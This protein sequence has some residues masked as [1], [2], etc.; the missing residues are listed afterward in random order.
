M[1]YTRLPQSVFRANPGAAIRA[2]MALAI[3]AMVMAA[4]LAPGTALAFEDSELVPV[5]QEQHFQIEDNTSGDPEANLP[6]LFAVF[7]ITWGL[8]FGYVFYMTM[9]QRRMQAE[10]EALRDALNEKIGTAP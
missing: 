6:Y 9:K 1:S 8:F 2:V 7:I 4:L 3:A 5:E 10:I